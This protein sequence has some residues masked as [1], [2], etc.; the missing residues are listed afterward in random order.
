MNMK[1]P[2]LTAL[3][4]PLLLVLST[5][6]IRAADHRDS[7]TADATSEG[8]ITDYFNF[9][10]PNDTTKIVFIMNV[11]PF[12]V[13]GEAANYRYSHDLLYQFKIDNTGDGKED[14][15]IQVV[16]S[17]TTACASG[18]SLSVYGPGTPAHTGAK[19]TVMGG[20][21]SVTGCTNTTLTAGSMQVFT[22][23]RDDPFVFDLAQFSRILK[24]TQDV[25]RDLPT[26]PLGHLRGR[27]VRADGTSGVDVF[28]GFD[29]SAIAI[30][31]PVSRVTTRASLIYTWATVSSAGGTNGR[32]DITYH[33]FQRMGQQAFKTVFVPGGALREEFN[34][35]VPQN[36][37]ANWSYLVPDA[38]TSTNT[39][40]NAI[41]DRYKLLDSL[42]LFS[43][44]V[45]APALLPSTF[46]NT[47]VSLLRN[48]T[49][50]DV[51]RINLGLDPG[52]L[53]VGVTGLQNGRRPG[54][55]AIDI[56]VRLIRQL[57]DIDFAG[58]GVNPGQ[59]Q[60]PLQNLALPI[61]DRRVL[62][63]L[64]GTDFIRPDSTLSD[65]SQ[66]GNDRPLLTLFPFEALPHPVPG[67]PGTIGYP[68]QQ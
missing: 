23:L 17:D 4:V 56:L 62:V 1:T 39:T 42:G 67:E 25:F 14:T 22:G 58:T 36:D 45:G 49:L 53:A 27:P 24:G 19:N 31:V 57:A 41:S 64:Q 44:G 68:V 47:N 43:A 40:G 35:S 28:G 50:P 61:T 10:D 65:L 30:E 20:I 15:V 3:A 29:I 12:A 32:G 60:F 48:A 54:D 7:P 34:A 63:V 2:V 38:L 5:P 13:P 21:P 6:G 33:Q 52:N 59:L 16:F 51:I 37:V 18:Q 8:D 55:D 9:L 66:S 11:N 26:T 46:T